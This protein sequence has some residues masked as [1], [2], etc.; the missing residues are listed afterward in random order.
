MG[1]WYVADEWYDVSVY[2]DESV[3]ELVGAVRSVQLR[4]V[5]PY[6]VDEVPLLAVLY[7]LC[8]ALRAS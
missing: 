5:G 3:E 4:E 1:M 2:A 6:V 7:G 8:A